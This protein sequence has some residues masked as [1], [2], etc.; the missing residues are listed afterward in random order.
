MAD[1]TLLA[2]PSLSVWFEA[3]G[4]DRLSMI[5]IGENGPLSADMLESISRKG[6]GG[7]VRVHSGHG[8][9]MRDS[10]L[11]EELRMRG[12]KVYAQSPTAVMAG[13]DKAF[14]RRLMQDAAVP[15]TAWGVDRLPNRSDILVKA[16]DSTQSRSIRWASGAGAI[17]PDKY[18]EQ[19][20]DGFEFS[21]T[22]YRENGALTLLPIVAKGRTRRDLLPPWRRLRWVRPGEPLPF[23]DTMYDTSCTIAEA[24]DIWGFFEVEFVTGHEVRVIEVNP[25]ISGTLRL[26]AMAADTKIFSPGALAASPR[27]MQPV[28]SGLELPFD[29]NPILEPRLIATSRLSCVGDSMAYVVR[30]VAARVPGAIHALEEFVGEV[31]N[32]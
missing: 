11:A 26:A 10:L 13:L 29:G 21:V 20:I 2:P 18:W 8:S 24:L 22:G 19:W 25:R 23:A 28:F 4:G 5:P 15:L 17:G 16:R 32:D 31:G 3:L 27:I 12:A 14:A 6:N 30:Q 1:L 7:T 9:L